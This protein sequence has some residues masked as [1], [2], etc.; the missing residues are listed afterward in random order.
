MS[1]PY[2]TGD[3]VRNLTGLSTSD[4]SDALL[5]GIIT[6]AVAQLNADVQTSWSNESV[7][8]IN[9][10]KEND[11]DG[12][13]TKFYTT[14]FPIGDRDNDGIISGVDVYAYVIDSDGARSQI[15]VS[16]IASDEVDPASKFGGPLWLTSAPASTDKLYFSYFSSPVDMET[17]HPLVKLACVQLSAA[18]S[19]TKIDVGKVQSFSVGKI[20]VMRQSDA[21]NIYERMYTKT[22]NKIRQE[23]FMIAYGTKNL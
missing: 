11:I 6:F 8:Y 5:S 16:G 9:S 10:E 12:S 19:F 23:M 17:P 13:N 15:I 14:H 3:D 7:S 2:C 20:R 22:I 18:L 21:Y 1:S 4:I